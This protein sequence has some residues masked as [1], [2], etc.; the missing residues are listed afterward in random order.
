MPDTPTSYRPA[1]AQP[2]RE[3][4]FRRAAMPGW[5]GSGDPQSFVTAIQREQPLPCHLTV[6]YEDSRWETQWDRQEIGSTCTGSLI[7]S[8]NMCKIPRDRSFPRAP[9]DRTAVF[10]HPLEFI[11]HHEAADVRSWDMPDSRSSRRG[12]RS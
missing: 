7:M 12:G 8:A 5:L 2:C 4:P 6:D 9:A 10:S 11:Q 1:L 3:C